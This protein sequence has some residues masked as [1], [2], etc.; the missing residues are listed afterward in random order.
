MVV[1]AFLIIGT[2]QWGLRLSFGVFFKSIEGE[3]DLTRAA[4]SSVLSA[5][6]VLGTLF[7]VLGGWFLD[8]YGPK[9]VV[10]L[11]GITTGLGLLLSSQINSLWQLYITYSLLLAMGTSTTYLVTISTI[12]RWFDKKRGIAL[13]IATSGAG[14]GPLIIAP[15]ATY[16]ISNFDWRMAYLVIGIIVWLLVIPLSRLLKKDPREIGAF[17]DGA[18]SRPATGH[19]QYVDSKKEGTRLTDISLSQAF[20][21]RSLWLLVFIYFLF[22]SAHLF[23]LTHIVP[24][25]TD[26]G[27][28]AIEA[29][30]VISLVGVGGI[31]GRVLMGV[32]S[33]RIGKILSVILCTLIM[34][35][36]IA[37]VLWSH[38]LWEFYLI[39]AVYGFAYGGRGPI[40]GSLVGDIFGLT[41][42]GSILG[43][44]EVGFNLGAATGPAIGG[45]IYDINQSYSLAFSSAA[46]LMLVT[47]ILTTLVRRENR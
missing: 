41:K 6:M 45:L 32:F 34:S 36:A 44:V 10:L 39:A 24:H 30:T 33:D 3:F 14:L 23:Y 17:P 27:F 16:L 2:A 19:S 47:A 8:K 7:V 29:A 12:S 35:G 46:I 18:V 1:L 9:I 4:T 26:I 5:Y 31:A 42:M 37:W 13:G 21:T 40:I 15:L 38:E 11:M 28:S 20:R 43:V 22:S 25:M